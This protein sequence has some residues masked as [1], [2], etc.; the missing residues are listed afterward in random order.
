MSRQIKSIYKGAFWLGLAQL[1]SKLLSAL[2]K[3]PLQNWT[4]DAGFYVYQQ[5]YPFYALMAHFS[6]TALPLFISKILSDEDHQDQLQRVGWDIFASLFFFFSMLALM[7]AFFARP[8]AYW[9]GDPALAPLLKIIALYYP[10]VALLSSL[11]A[12]F[13]SQLDMFPSALSHLLE[14]SIRVFLI[15][16]AAYLFLKEKLSLY[17]M[18]AWSY[19]GAVLAGL[20]AAAYLIGAARGKFNLPFNSLFVQRQAK[21]E[22]IKKNGR[23]FFQEGLVFSLLLSFLLVLQL[24]DSFTLLK[25]LVQSGVDL[26]EARL[27]KGVYDRGLPLVQVGVVLASALSAYMLPALNRLKRQQGGQAFRSAAQSFVKLIFLFSMAASLG[28]IFIMP[29][30]NPLLFQDDKGTVTL[31]I[32]A[33][34]V[35]WMSM[36]M[37]LLNLLQMKASQSSLWWPLI[38]SLFIKYLANRWLVASLGIAGA[39]LASQLTLIFLFLYLLGQLRKENHFFILPRRQLLPSFLAFIFMILSVCFSRYVGQL[40][41]PPNSWG[42]LMEVVLAVGAG[43][44]SFI[45]SLDR[46]DLLTLEEWQIL[47]AHSLWQKRSDKNE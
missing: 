44:S 1:I 3:V 41:F 39:A 47:P 12:Y 27:A 40:L 11:R 22:S 15:L 24:L 23:L 8:L 38:I 9:M 30:L 16:L 7:L 13:Q 46:L 5:V 29:A 25:T 28:L 33:G 17:T 6:L 42:L 4:G 35:F 32:L 2:Y 45:F 43:A 10:G 36:I 21:R 14:Q 37:A 18:G 31:A 26:E 19:A 20:V 34:L